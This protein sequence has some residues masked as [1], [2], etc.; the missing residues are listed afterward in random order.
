[1]SKDRA[2]AQALIMPNSEPV[3]ETLGRLTDWR[4]VACDLI[5]AEQKSRSRL[6]ERLHGELQQLLTVA[7]MRTWAAKRLTSHEEL[8]TVLAEVESVV[9]ESIDETR[10][11]TLDLSPPI[12]RHSAF[13]KA[14]EWIGERMA[15]LH[16]L[17][18]KLA[19]HPDAELATPAVKS[20][21]F[22]A[23]RSILIDRA[24]SDGHQAA[25]L[26]VSRVDA[27]IR[28]D[29]E[30][31][32]RDGLRLPAVADRSVRDLPLT[33]QQIAER[34]AV[35]RGRISSHVTPEGGERIVLLVPVETS[36]RRGELQPGRVADG[37][38]NGAGFALSTEVPT[39]V[40]RILLAEDHHMVR[41]GLARLINAEPDLRVI[42]QAGDGDKAVEMAAK[43]N[44]DVVV[45]DV[46]M[47]VRTGTEA[48]RTIKEN[49]PHMKIVG[50]SEYGDRVTK[51]AMR[52]AGASAYVCKDS[53]S[54]ELC[55]VIRR[56]VNG[57]GAKRSTR[58]DSVSRS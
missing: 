10:T 7:L 37:A 46:N 19:I 1:M 56:A 14:M 6:A 35:L 23:V 8:L 4:Q 20:F 54:E 2:L 32:T 34:V 16:G 12:L 47:P 3:V 27:G 15:E 29:I 25:Q 26:A 36:S 49:S 55:R 21:L 31:P 45:L 43:L 48:A 24:V 30:F 52:D 39:G 40:I 50:L 22:D 17:S 58:K 33:Q 11:L 9:R 38:A 28:V 42:G 51:R 5:E 13:A 57:N 53:A 41:E 18:V 44:P